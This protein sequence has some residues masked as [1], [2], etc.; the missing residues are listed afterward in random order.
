MD[1][2]RR[3]GGKLGKISEMMGS[4]PRH[5]SEMFHVERSRLLGMCQG[6]AEGLHNGSGRTAGLESLPRPDRVR[7]R[8]MLAVTTLTHSCLIGLW[9]Y[10]Y[11]SVE[12]VQLHEVR[13]SVSLNRDR[14]GFQVS[15]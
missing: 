8:A 4:T 12:S 11:S 13:D 10:A 5:L 3:F 6:R 15:S 1:F 14:N 2:L 9:L 7:Q